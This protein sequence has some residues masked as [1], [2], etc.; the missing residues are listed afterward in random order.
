MPIITAYC[1]FQQELRCTI[2]Y[3]RH[4]KITLKT[5]TNVFTLKLYSS[6]YIE[7]TIE[8]GIQHPTYYLNKEKIELSINY[9]KEKS[10]HS[11]LPPT[12]FLFGTTCFEQKR[13]EDR[14]RYG[15]ATVEN[16]WTQK[17]T[18]MVSQKCDD[19]FIITKFI[20]T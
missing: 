4:V 20:R 18:R 19:K 2:R 3:I 14:E 10:L 17:W 13:K 1:H 5:S 6:A 7:Q 12:S 15:G 9:P 11:N 16:Q 8:H